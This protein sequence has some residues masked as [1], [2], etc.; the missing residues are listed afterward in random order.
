MTGL[1]SVALNLIVLDKGGLRHDGVAAEHAP[2]VEG[3][4]CF[5]A[6]ADSGSSPLQSGETPCSLTVVGTA[7]ALKAQTE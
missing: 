7:M 6:S 4:R 2:T 5:L 3:L 1:D